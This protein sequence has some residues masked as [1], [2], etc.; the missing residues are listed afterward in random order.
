MLARLILGLAMFLVPPAAAPGPPPTVVVAELFTSEGCSSCPP[1]DTLMRQL[2]DAP[3]I[4]GTHLIALEEHVDYWDRLGW[5]DPFSSAQFTNRQTEY[6]E[7]V[8]R[9]DAIYTP[10]LV[11]DGARECVGSDRSAIRAIVADSVRRPHAA[12]SVQSVAVASHLAVTV[13]VDVPAAVERRGVA[14]VFVVVAER[15]LVSVVRR[16]ENGG[17]TLAH[18]AVARLLAP[19]GELSKH[20]RV[21][22]GTANV[23][24]VRNWNVGNLQIVGV[25]QE[26]DSRRIIGAAASEISSRP[27]SD[28]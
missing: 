18:G 24:V 2:A 11:V 3:P 14:D 7:R 27:G 28:R 5:R 12:V 23:E 20:D 8:F 16:G 13:S 21:F 25:I 1:A 15:N 19:I 26:R 22:A 17:R 6:N 9:S 4:D 10:Q